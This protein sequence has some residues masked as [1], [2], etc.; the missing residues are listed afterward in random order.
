M[1]HTLFGGVIKKPIF[2]KKNKTLKLDLNVNKVL[3]FTVYESLI[4][5]LEKTIW[6]H[7]RTLS[8]SK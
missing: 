7:C 5:N 4:V 8:D 6:I 1:M 3:P 2:N